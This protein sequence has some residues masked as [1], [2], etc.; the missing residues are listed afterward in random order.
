MC[1]Y[2][3]LHT[4]LEYSDGACTEILCAPGRCDISSTK[5]KRI[6]STCMC[7]C[8][9]ASVAQLVEQLP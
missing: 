9:V 1:V 3:S 7:M 6:Q 2:N 8:W 4:S 5:L